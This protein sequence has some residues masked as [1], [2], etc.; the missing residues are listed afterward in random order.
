MSKDLRLLLVEDSP[1]DAE[2]LL[3]ELRRGGYTPEW[4]RVQ[5][6]EELRAALEQ[7]TWDLVLADYSLPRFSA[8]E[9]FAVV[10]ELGIDVPFIIVSGTVGEETAVA[11]MRAGVH[12][13]LLKDKLTRLVAAAERELREAELRAERRKM[14]QRLFTADRMVSVGTLAAGVAHE[15]N[16]PLAT[17]MLGLEISLERL[18]QVGSQVRGQEDQRAGSRVA[19][20]LSE[21]EAG[22]RDAHEASERVCLIAQDLRSFSWAGSDDPRGPVDVERVLESSLRLAWNAIRYRSRLV[23]SYGRVPAV[24]GSEPRLGQVFLNL[25]MNAAQAIPEGALE[26]HEIQVTTRSEGARVAVEIQDTGS[27]IP[28]DALSRIFEAFFTTKPF[29]VGTGLGLTIC[30]QIVSGLGGE[31]SVTSEL[32]KGSLFRVVLPAA[33]P[34]AEL[35]AADAQEPSSRD[36]D[37]RASILVVDDDPVICSVVR[38]V[39]A[40]EYDVKSAGSVAEALAQLGEPGA[41]FDVILSD[42]HM[43]NGSGM[44]LHEALVRKAPRLAARLAFMI[45]GITTPGAREFLARIPNLRIDKPFDAQTLRALV[46]EV[47]AYRVS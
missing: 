33:G 46:R 1:D 41:R 17:V 42:M 44:D 3:R 30:Q 38:R 12:D 29:G 34:A 21:I 16:G 8:P 32:G 31:I 36:L 27:G 2:L 35:D 15:I 10:K 4:L 19:A 24:L 26:R 22:L 5:T 40:R 43:A 37:D 18:A 9:A 25:L 20:Q 7:R 47:L 14:Q 6:R 39:F 13:Y 11:A 28:A 45:G 23:R